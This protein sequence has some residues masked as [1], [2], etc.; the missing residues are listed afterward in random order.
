MM[1][2][3]SFFGRSVIHRSVGFYCT[4]VD[5]YIPMGGMLIRSKNKGN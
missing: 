3:R 1:L 5:D 4:K 2:R